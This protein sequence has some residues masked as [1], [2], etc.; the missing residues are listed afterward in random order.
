MLTFHATIYYDV[1][2]ASGIKTKAV[3]QTRFFVK[4]PDGLHVRNMRDDGVYGF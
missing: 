2:E 4:R 3:T 1:V